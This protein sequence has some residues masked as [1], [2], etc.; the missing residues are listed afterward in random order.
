MALISCPE[1]SREVSDRAP[2]C[3]NCGYPIPEPSSEQAD[4]MAKAD[5][6]RDA[7][8]PGV[9]KIAEDKAR[10]AGVYAPEPNPQPIV[11]TRSNG[12]AT[13]SFVLAVIGAVLGIVPILALFALILGVLAV[14][15]GFAGRKR[16]KKGETTEGKGMAKSGIIIGFIAIV[17][18]IIGFAIVSDAFSDLERELENLGAGLGVLG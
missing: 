9:A 6:L 5:D 18:A 11:P 4:L 13:A 7:G 1:C 17:L 16:I 14:I 2:A 12:M 15:F 8:M 10:Q 3:P